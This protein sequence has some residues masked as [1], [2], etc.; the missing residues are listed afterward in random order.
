MEGRSCVE[1]SGRD[2]N[3]PSGWD[4]TEEMLINAIDEHG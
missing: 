4:R 3:L 1:E 2:L